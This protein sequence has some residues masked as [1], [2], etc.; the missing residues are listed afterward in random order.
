MDGIAK[1]TREKKTGADIRALSDAELLLL[2]RAIEKAR[3]AP[4]II[5]AFKV[6]ALTGQRPAEIAGLALSE[7]RHLDNP[8]KAVAELPADRMKARRGTCGRSAS[9]CAAS[10]TSRRR[11]AGRRIRLR[12]E[13]FRSPEHCPA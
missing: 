4:G 7:L 8:A 1:P 5:A 9:Q 10:S 12:L 13:V 6:L 3:L 2:W 11:A